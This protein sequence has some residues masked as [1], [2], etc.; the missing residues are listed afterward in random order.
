MIH[1][2]ILLLMAQQSD[3]RGDTDFQARLQDVA[4]DFVVHAY[5]SRSPVLKPNV[6]DQD[7]LAYYQKHTAE[8]MDV[9]KIRISRIV[10]RTARDAEKIRVLI[11]LGRSFDKAAEMIFPHLVSFLSEDIIPQSELTADL[12]KSMANLKPGHISDVIPTKAGYEVA[13][14]LGAIPPTVKPFNTVLDVA[15]VRCALSQMDQTLDKLESKYK[16]PDS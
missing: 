9:P 14:Y 16:H 11:T 12:K 5:Q 2:R 3:L 10:V 4:D 8:F 6:T 15:R 7:A 1:D 13:K